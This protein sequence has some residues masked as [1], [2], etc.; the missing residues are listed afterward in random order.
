MFDQTF[1]PKT[2]K[3]HCVLLFFGHNLYQKHDFSMFLVLGST[4]IM[5]RSYFLVPK[6]SKYHQ[7]IINFDIIFH[8]FS[9]KLNVSSFLEEL[10]IFDNLK[11]TGVIVGIRFII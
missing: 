3:N 11:R 8:H 7:N 4:N 1:D 2:C 6:S 10:P 9:I 5:S